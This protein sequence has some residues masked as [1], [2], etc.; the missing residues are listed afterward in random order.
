MNI[1]QALKLDESRKT[2]LIN[3]MVGPL[4]KPIAKKF[5]GVDGS[6]INEG[7]SERETLYMMYVLKRREGSILN[8]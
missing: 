7:F 4:L 3:G 6:R 2:E 5:S 8:E 1:V